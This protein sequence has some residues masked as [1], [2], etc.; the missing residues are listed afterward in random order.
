MGDGGQYLSPL[1]CLGVMHWIWCDVYAVWTLVYGHLEAGRPG[2]VLD[3]AVGWCVSEGK[4]VSDE[5]EGLVSGPGG[6]VL[7]W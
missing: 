1:P 5:F 6:V 2:L 4:H 3:S 7:E